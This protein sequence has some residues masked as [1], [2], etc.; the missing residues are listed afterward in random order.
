MAELLSHNKMLPSSLT[1]VLGWKYPGPY[2]PAMSELSQQGE[3]LD[4][5]THTFKVEESKSFLPRS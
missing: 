3:N 1:L 2:F 5:D 4:Y